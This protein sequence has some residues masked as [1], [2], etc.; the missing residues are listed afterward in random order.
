MAIK[1][2]IEKYEAKKYDVIRELIEY[3]SIANKTKLKV[4]EEI[5]NDLYNIKED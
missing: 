4:Y 3:E 2:L 5:L 1:E